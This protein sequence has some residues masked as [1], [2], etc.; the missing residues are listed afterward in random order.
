MSSKLLVAKVV[1]SNETLPS[2]TAILDALRRSQPETDEIGPIQH[3]SELLIFPFGGDM[4]AISLLA[5]PLPPRE[6]DA[7][8]AAAWYWPDAAQTLVSQ[9]AQVLVGVLPESGDRIGAALRL[10]ALASVVAETSASLGVFWGPS[11]LIHAPNAFATYAQQMSRQALPLYLWID[12]HVDADAQGTHSL[13]TRGLAVFQ[14]MEIEVYG[15][16]K[17]P[18]ELVAR[19]YDIVHYVLAKNAVLHE[20]ETIGRTNEERISVH[21]GPSRQDLEA[22]VIQLEI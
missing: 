11:C 4:A 10:T 14:S 9:Q 2:E 20:G 1:V 6:R 12:F 22:R 5:E 7:A 19:V 21:L 15:S 13:Y 17:S 18:Q 8:C 3:Q 16:S